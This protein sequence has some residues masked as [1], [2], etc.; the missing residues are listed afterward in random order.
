M[1]NNI[2]EDD[3]TPLVAPSN[4]QPP[5][6]LDADTPLPVKKKSYRQVQKELFGEKAGGQ[7]RIGGTPRD[8]AVSLFAVFYLKDV[9]R[10]RFFNNLP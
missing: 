1:N 5:P 8:E 3:A 6:Y 9:L 7:Y 4:L 10:S 2:Y